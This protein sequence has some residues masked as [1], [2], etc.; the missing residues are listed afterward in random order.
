VAGE[1]DEDAEFLSQENNITPAEEINV[2][3]DSLAGVGGWSHYVPGI[4]AEG[5]FDAFPD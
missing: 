5:T 4:N 2:D 1:G 3:L